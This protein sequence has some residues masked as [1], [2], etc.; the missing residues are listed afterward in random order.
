MENKTNIQKFWDLINLTEDYV[1][2]GFRSGHPE[3]QVKQKESAEDH[4]PRDKRLEALR[5][6][7]LTCKKC[8][9]HYNRANAIP[10]E[11]KLDADLFI[12]GRGPDEEEDSSGKP[13]VGKT[14]NYLD[15]WL[16]AIQLRLSDH[17]FTCTIVRCRPP[18]NRE[19]RMEE[20][21][22]CFSY[23][24][25]QIA[26]VNPGVIL[27]LGRIP[28][29]MLTQK[30]TTSVAKLRGQPFTYKGIPLIV[31]YHP[32]MVLQN[33]DLRKPVWEDLKR[34]KTLIEKRKK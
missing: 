8:H 33:K 2:T 15:K 25:E 26:I 12:V 13:F 14:G 5:N 18:Q 10:G 1:S 21:R 32:A 34:L 28:G 4:I 30:L 19:P 31:T 3:L 29:Q 7:I 11:G 27:C 6:T 9:L 22:S 20:A 17:C 16:D 24:D 23:V